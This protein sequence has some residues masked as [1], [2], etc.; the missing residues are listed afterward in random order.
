[1]L[2]KLIVYSTNS[3]DSS[4]ITDLYGDKDGLGIGV[5]DGDAFDFNAVI[6]DDTEDAGTITDTWMSGTQSW[7]HTYDLTG[8]GPITSASWEIFTGGQ[9]WTG[10]SSLFID[11]SFVGNLT[12]GD[13]FDV[14]GDGENRGRLDVFDLSSFSGFLN[15]ANTL[16]VDTVLDGDGWALDYSELRIETAEP[17]TV[18]EPSTLRALGL[19]G[20]VLTGV[21][22]SKRLRG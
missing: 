5:G 9:G 13:G 12:D 15:S 10:L 20:L 6:A 8:L 4:T 16:T 22:R 7:S 18:P 19:I 21:S 1:M 14:G 3:L 17:A 11:G 2:I